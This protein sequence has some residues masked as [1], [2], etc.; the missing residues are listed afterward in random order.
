MTYRGRYAIKLNQTKSNQTKH[1]Q[2]KP[3]T[4][5]PRALKLESHYI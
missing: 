2:T 4:T 5:L 1:Y 3:N